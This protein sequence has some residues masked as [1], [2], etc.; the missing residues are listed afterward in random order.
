MHLPLLHRLLRLRPLVLLLALARPARA[1]P[2]QA[3]LLAVLLLHRLAAALPLDPT[4]LRLVLRRALLPLVSVVTTRCTVRMR[5]PFK[6]GYPLKPT[7]LHYTL[8]ARIFRVWMRCTFCCSPFPS[9]RG[10]ISTHASCRR[11][12]MITRG[13][14]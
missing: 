9:T 5:S 12:S 4:H 7:D 13:S 6:S 14:P 8:N 11:G 10:T 2:L 1:D 3:P